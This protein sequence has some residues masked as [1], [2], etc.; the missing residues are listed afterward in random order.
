MAFCSIESRGKESLTSQGIPNPINLR[1]WMQFKNARIGKHFQNVSGSDPSPS[2]SSLVGKHGIASMKLEAAEKT[3]LKDLYTR[4]PLLVQRALYPDVSMPH[5]AHIYLMSSAGSILENDRF[6]IR[7]DA[8][9]N[10]CSSITTQAA[11]KVHPMRQGY[12]GQY[13]S[14][15]LGR[16]VYLEYVPDQI[17]PYS[18]SRYHQEVTINIRDDSF[19]I[20]AETLSAGRIASNEVFDFDVCVLKTRIIDNEKGLLLNDSIKL[21]PSKNKNEILCVFGEKVVIFTAYLVIGETNRLLTTDKLNR[22][23]G[24]NGKILS[25]FSQMPRRRGY[26]VRILSDSVDD[27]VI[28]RKL[29]VKMIRNAYLIEPV[30]G[31]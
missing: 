23:L 19:M 21:E 4:P 7:I 29:L 24:S 12:A 1:F 31:D 13:T 8:G 20:Y 6:D 5:M 14:I 17:I 27:I 28:V 10:T 3:Y 22:I 2:I 26:V 11:S 15:N 18:S 30:T 16:N 25:G 9:S